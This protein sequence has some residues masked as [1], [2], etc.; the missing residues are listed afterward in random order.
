[1]CIYYSNFVQK[2]EE[3]MTAVFL[4]VNKFVSSGEIH[5]AWM[6]SINDRVQFNLRLLYAGQTHRKCTLSSIQLNN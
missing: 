4:D 3:F 6:E 5:K 2:A 1:M